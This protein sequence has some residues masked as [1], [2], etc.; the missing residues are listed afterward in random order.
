VH[1]SIADALEAA[2]RFIGIEQYDVEPLFFQQQGADAA[3]RAS[4]DNGYIE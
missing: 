1:Q 4:A 3:G 2:R